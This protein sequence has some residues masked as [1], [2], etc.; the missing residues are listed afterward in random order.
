M[1][2]IREFSLIIPPPSL[3]ECSVC[4][5]LP[6]KTAKGRG[7]VPTE[8]RRREHRVSELPLKSHWLFSGEY[9]WTPAAL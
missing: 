3:E 1:Q 2:L 6:G 4:V 5:T 9:R 8:E 7:E